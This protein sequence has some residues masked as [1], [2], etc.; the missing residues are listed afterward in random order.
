[1][2]TIAKLRHNG[3]VIRFDTALLN[4]IEPRLFDHNW[5]R[6]NGHLDG[7]A[8]GR[9]QA[10]FLNFA[11]RQMVLRAFMR[12]GL[13]GKINRDLFGRVGADKSRAMREFDLLNWM[14]AKGLAVPRAVAARYVPVGLFYR[15]QII[16]ER[17]PHTRP[18]EDI[19][20]STAIPPHQWAAVGAAV[21][22]MHDHGVFH[23]DLNCR[24]ILMDRQEK[25]WLIDFDK[26]KRRTPGDWTVQNLERL[27]RSLRKG[28]R[29]YQGFHWAEQDWADLISGYDGTT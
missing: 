4:P 16:T 2:G 18:L 25:V 20:R 10:Y 17:I 6:A 13:I 12:G 21:K 15:A 22:Q 7:K 27:R 26:C 1:M 23:S 3:A 5:V 8:K 9:G 24:N 29:N 14:H 19:L 11:D 28:R